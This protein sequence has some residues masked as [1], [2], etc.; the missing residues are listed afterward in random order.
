MTPSKEFKAFFA[1]ICVLWS[2][3]SLGLSIACISIMPSDDRAHEILYPA[4]FFLLLIAAVAVA[5]IPMWVLWA[6]VNDEV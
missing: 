2:A 3:A 5:F 4:T 1:V 6:Y